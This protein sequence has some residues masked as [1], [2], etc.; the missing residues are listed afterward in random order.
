MTIL[1]IY[2]HLLNLNNGD[3]SFQAKTL[4]QYPAPLTLTTGTCLVGA[5]I[6]F[7]VAQVLGSRYGSRWMIDW[8]IMFLSY[9]YAVSYINVFWNSTN[10]DASMNY[11]HDT[12][13]A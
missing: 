8:N 12:K 13:F 1:D 6:N 11:T 5:L 4:P 9:F 7:T 10:T 3:F 2:Y